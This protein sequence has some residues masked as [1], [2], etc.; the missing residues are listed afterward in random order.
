YNWDSVG[1][2]GG[3]EQKGTILV[4]DDD[5]LVRKSIERILSGRGYEAQTASSAEEAKQVLGRR[6]YDLV[7]TDLEMPGEDGMALLA[8]IKRRLPDTGVVM[9]T[10]HGSK[11][12]VIEALRRGVDDFLEKPY[13][14]HE[15]INVVDREVARG[16]RNA[17][18]GMDAGLGLQLEVAQFDEIEQML[19][20]LRA[21][22]N[23]RSVFVVQGNGSVIATKGAV[24]DLNISAL[25]AL[26]A[27]D[28]AATAEIASLIGEERA[29]K[30]NYHEGTQYSVY[31]AQV[32]PGVF[33]LVI[34]SP[35]IKLGVVMYYTN[36]ILEKL[37]AIFKDAVTS[38]PEGHSAREPAAP[39]PPPTTEPEP[40]TEPQPQRPAPAPEDDAGLSVSDSDELFSFEQILESGML[41]GELSSA[42][43]SQLNDLWEPS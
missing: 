21:E 29:F 15:L 41:D 31:S 3:M 24:K 8:H 23:A 13:K 40:E 25:A 38:P 11:D 2:S 22:A 7:I 10:G 43:E 39:S 18:P 37:Q 32:V 16:R 6:F 4:V 12:V 36:T 27:G 26:V 35:D 30:L 14:P 1:K 5:I 42:L 33:L 34:F 9:L 28:F 17:P 19:A 20:E